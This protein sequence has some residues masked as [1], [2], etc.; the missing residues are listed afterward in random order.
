[1]KI[2]FSELLASERIRPLWG[3]SYTPESAMDE[4]QRI[5]APDA[6]QEES[7]ATTGSAGPGPSGSHPGEAKDATAGS[8]PLSTDPGN[9]RPEQTGREG[10]NRSTESN[11][12]SDTPSAAG[13]KQRQ[14]GESG[15]VFQVPPDLADIPIRPPHEI[16]AELEQAVAGDLGSRA[17]MVRN[18]IEALRVRIHS[19][20]PTADE[21]L[22]HPLRHAAGGSIWELLMRMEDTLSGLRR[23]A[24]GR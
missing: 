18:F 16:F 21:A 14:A 3:R 15:D 17:S 9:T 2:N 7:G 8:R 6:G 23:V 19:L 20:D 1:M 11:N 4:L 10:D 13:A 22:Y 5:L 12:G 24:S